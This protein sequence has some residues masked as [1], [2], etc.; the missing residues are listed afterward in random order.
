[1]IPQSIH[2]ILNLEFSVLQVLHLT[3]SCS[4]LMVN[5]TRL[6]YEIFIMDEIIGVT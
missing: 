4:E 6:D 3:T 1:M 5:R 2:F